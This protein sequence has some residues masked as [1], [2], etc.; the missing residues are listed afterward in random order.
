MKILI[1]SHKFSPDIGG[2]ETVS[3][4]LAEEFVQSGHEVRI[5]TNSLDSAPQQFPFLVIRKP[6]FHKLFKQF[7]WAEVVFENNPC[8]RLTWPLFFVSRPKVT[9]LHTWIASIDGFIGTIHQIKKRYLKLSNIVAACSNSVRIKTFPEAIVMGNAYQ[10]DLFKIK[11]H[12]IR[13][14]HFVFLG[15]LVSDKGVDL[16]I[17][18]LSRINDINQGGYSLS[19]IGRGEEEIKLKEIVQILGLENNVTFLGS[20]EGEAL[21]NA[22]NQHKFIL[23]PSVW[24]EPFGIVALEGMACGC[25]PIVSD[26]GGLP[27]AVG[28]AGIVF[29]SGDVDDLVEKMLRLLHTPTLCTTIRNEIPKHLALHTSKIIANNYLGLINTAFENK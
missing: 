12:I 20:M 16:A 10:D 15:R 2:I 13:N 18:A 22:L 1:L 29:K 7:I 8:M 26:G 27:D 6:E 11:E 14:K 19:I 23:V 25:I 17:K 24:E 9:A 5:V 21:V 28:K 3:R 4:M